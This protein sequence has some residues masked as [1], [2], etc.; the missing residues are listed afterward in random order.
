M[1]P[2]AAWCERKQD[3]ASDDFAT[4]AYVSGRELAGIVHVGQ[5]AVAAGEE[6]VLAGI[7]EQ[8]LG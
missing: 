1:M 5:A 3:G 6:A 2:R 8:K 7:L 4:I